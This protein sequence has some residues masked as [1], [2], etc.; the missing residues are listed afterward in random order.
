MVPLTG[1]HARAQT[2]QTRQVTLIQDMGCAGLLDGQTLRYTRANLNDPD[3]Q[4][5]LFE[6]MRIQVKLLAAD[7]DVVA[8]DGAEAV[9]VGQFQSFDFNRNQLIL[10]G[11]PGTGRL[12]LRL[13]V[14]VIGRSK[15][16]N[17]VLKQGIVETFNDNAEIIDNSTGKTVVSLGGGTNEIVLNDSSGTE[18]VNRGIQITAAASEGYHVGFVPGQ[19]L[20][21]TVLYPIFLDQS[22]KPLQFKAMVNLFVADG[23]QIANSEETEIP[24]GEFRS[25]DF[26]AADLQLSATSRVQ[27]RVEI[28]GRFF[29]GVV[30]RISQGDTSAELVD[31]ATGK[32]AQYLNPRSFQIISA[33]QN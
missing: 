3:P 20:R 14:T 11:E 25:F 30:A 2:E 32:T 21:I 9:G 17:L 10:P 4:K 24:A 33:G 26:D 29:P 18:K 15:W 28:H 23:R 13:E 27:V 1:P 5:R 12:Q 19:R 7:G 16:P 6:P 8:Q 31:I 22:G